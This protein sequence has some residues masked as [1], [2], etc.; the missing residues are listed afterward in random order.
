MQERDVKSASRTSKWPLWS[1]LWGTLIIGPVL[2]PFGALCLL[3]AFA[4]ILCPPI[5]VCTLLI[6]G[7]Y[8]FGP[9]LLI[10]WLFWL[11]FG[12]RFLRWLLQ[13]IEWSSL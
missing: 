1:L 9:A 7:H 13:G 2:M 4:S 11:R 3:A 5:Y 6:E 12:F 10:G 8:F